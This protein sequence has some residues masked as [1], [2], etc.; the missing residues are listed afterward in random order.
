MTD[1]KIINPTTKGKVIQLDYDFIISLTGECE[2]CLTDAQVQIILGMLDYV[3][4]TTRWYSES[5]TLDPQIILD[6]QGGL[7]ERL[8]MGCCP[9]NSILYRYTPDGHYQSSTDGGTTWT[10]TPGADPR[11]PN[12]QFPPYL[13]PDTMDASCTYADS[14]S[15][16]VKTGMVD[17]L[18]D[19]MPFAD[20]LAILA[21]V[22]G[23]IMVGL[24][25]TVI[26]EI[27]VGILGAVIV[28]IIGLTIPLF[29]AAMTSDVYD[30]FRCNLSEHIESDG[31]F[32][33][34]DV[35]AIYTQIGS[36]E[37]GMAKAFLQGFVAAA[38]ATGLTNAARAGYGAP[39]ASCCP[40][41]GADWD[42]VTFD[43]HTVGTII[44]RGSNYITLNM[45]SH[46]D[47]GTPWNAM[48]E[49]SNDAD[50]CIIQNIEFLT[51]DGVGEV[52]FGVKCGNP[53]WPATSNSF[54]VLT[55][56]NMNTVY[57]RKD[58]GGDATVKIT[59]Q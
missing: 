19:G 49:G 32:T 51:G 15:K 22:F 29:Q 35:D 1:T 41:C 37:T 57:C 56:D 43:G 16:L 46:P 53:R 26:G 31:S 12:P 9:D 8:N 14:V 20:I 5:G 34:A 30:R 45:T 21:S 50:C 10:D 17:K 42:V 40:T 2:Y 3:G 58:S 52:Y 6:L 48:I 38:G 13:P 47:F 25:P 55:T 4:W 59:F 27:I 23:V 33:T 28:G 54:F 18:T 44:D 7:A 24:A 39:D 36:D 11:N